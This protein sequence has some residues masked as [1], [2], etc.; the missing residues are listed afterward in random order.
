MALQASIDALAWSRAS[1][2]LLLILATVLA[3]ELVSA[4]ARR[5]LA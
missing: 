5:A 1:T 3:A 4:R 2:V